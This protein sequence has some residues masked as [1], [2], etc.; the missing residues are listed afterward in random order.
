MFHSFL[1]VSPRVI[2]L[3]CCVHGWNSYPDRLQ[4]NWFLTIKH[5]EYGGTEPVTKHFLSCAKNQVRPPEI[6]FPY[7]VLALGKQVPS[8]R[9]FHE[10]IL[11]FESF[12]NLGPGSASIGGSTHGTWRGR[13][14]QGIPGF[15]PWKAALMLLWDVSVFCCSMYVRVYPSFWWDNPR[16]WWFLF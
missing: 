7:K 13:W 5:G 16:I 4:N 2:M 11:G 15:G 9:L 6:V 3:N 14:T 12:S 1:Y 8:P 10:R